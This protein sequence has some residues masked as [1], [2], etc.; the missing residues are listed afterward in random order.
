MAKKDRKIEW[1]SYDGDYPN[2]CRGVL[3]LKID[4]RPIKFGTDTSQF[5]GKATDLPGFWFSGGSWDITDDWMDEVEEGDWLFNW[6]PDHDFLTATE[7]AKIE[8]LF[9]EKVPKGCCGGCI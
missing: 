5:G 2:L 6:E 1:V 9:Q 8:K 7:K 3:T 4:G